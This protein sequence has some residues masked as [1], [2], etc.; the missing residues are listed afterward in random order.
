MPSHLP[1]FHFKNQ[2]V[3]IAPAH[4]SPGRRQNENPAQGHCPDSEDPSCNL[5]IMSI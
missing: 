4:I 3:V 5:K 1:F 2:L